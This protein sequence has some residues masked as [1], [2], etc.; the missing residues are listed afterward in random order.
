MRFNHNSLRAGLW[1]WFLSAPFLWALL[2]IALSSNDDTL[3]A[4][5]LPCTLASTVWRTVDDFQLAPGQRAEAWG[6]WVTPVGVVYVAGFAEQTTTSPAPFDAH[7]IVRKSSDFGQTWTTVRDLKLSATSLSLVDG[8]TARN[9]GQDL[10]GNVLVVGQ[11]GDGTTT[12][13]TV[14]RSINGGTSWTTSD[15]FQLTTTAGTGSG[16]W[17]F[18]PDVASSF[19]YVSGT[20]G[21]AGNIQHGIVRRSMDGGASWSTVED[22]TALGTPSF[23]LGMVR[24]QPGDLVYVGN[25]F[26]AWIAK[27]SA[28]GDLGSWLLEDSFLPGGFTGSQATSVFRDVAFN[29]YAAGFANTGSGVSTGFVRKSS[30]GGDNWTTVRQF[31]LA[32]GSST[33]FTDGTENLAGDIFVSMGA[34]DASSSRWLVQR[35]SDGGG[36]WTT[37]DDFQLVAGSQ[38]IARRIAS[39]FGPLESLYAVGFAN[40]GTSAASNHWIVRKI[41]I[42]C[43]DTVL[44]G[45]KKVETAATSGDHTCAIVADPATGQLSSKCWGRND[46][47]QVGNG[48]T[49]PNVL[50][51]VQLPAN[52]VG[53][54]GFKQID[55]GGEHTC[56]VTATDSATCWGSN[57]FG[58]LGIGNTVEQHAPANVLG[59]SSV[60]R[61]SAGAVHTCAV[62]QSFSATG[63]ACWGRGGANGALGNSPSS[64]ISTVPV[65]VVGLEFGLTFSFIEDISAGTEHTCAVVD[66]GALCWGANGQGQLGDTTTTPSQV[67]VAVSL[68]PT[69]IVRQVSASNFFSCALVNDPPVNGKVFCWGRDAQ[70]QVGNGAPASSLPSPTP[71]EVVDSVTGL[72]IVDAVQISTGTQHACA[73][74]GNGDIRC[75]GLNGSGQIGE[76]RMTCPFVCPSAVQVMG[77]QGLKA[78]YVSAG[79]DYTCAVLEDS[80]AACWGER[81]NYKLGDGGTTL[82]NQLL[83][84]AVLRP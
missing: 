27:K 25:A 34:S 67:P 63:A 40:D 65:P 69:V 43:A 32:P 57:I 56:A 68:P 28:T 73:L 36:T 41:N 11:V 66:A 46:V 12:H 38:A 75:W 31:Q 42:G 13:W 16:A 24:T 17:A 64:F 61:V 6:V 72:P 22:Q 51:G 45:V 58:R 78:T 30:D 62:M 15:D 81:S 50:S 23:A 18:L 3:H 33:F 21:D 74:F 83:P 5:P 79:A 20:G 37:E 60:V 26:P 47:G 8:A 7:W 10:S 53:S 70:G 19:L 29:L 39:G 59:L 80:I 4:Q 52:V 2:H 14:E 82:G 71:V 49:V 76:Q 54:G 1:R 84:T 48:S 77:L 55:L 9:V 35:S 44:R